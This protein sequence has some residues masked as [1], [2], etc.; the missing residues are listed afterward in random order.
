MKLVSMHATAAA[1]AKQIIGTG[2]SSSAIMGEAI[3]KMRAKK[4]QIPKEVAA[5]MIGN[6]EACEM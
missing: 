3:A 2:C 4:L 6:N 5:N 1:I